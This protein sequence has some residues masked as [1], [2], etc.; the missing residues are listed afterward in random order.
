MGVVLFGAIIFMT[1]NL[2]VDISYH[3]LDPR[4]RVKGK[5]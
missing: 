3:F 1:M 5:P 2:L 4:V